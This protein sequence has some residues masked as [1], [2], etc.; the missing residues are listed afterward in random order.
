MLLHIMY[1][2]VRYEWDGEKNRTNQSKHHG[3]TFETAQEVF[4]DPNQVVLENYFLED[5]GEQRYQ[6]IGIDLDFVLPVVFVNRSI[7]GEEII[8]IVSAQERPSNMKKQPTRSNS[9]RRIKVTVQ[10]PLSMFLDKSRRI[11]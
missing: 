7:E 6:A 3:I 4:D 11:V 8:H 1:N 2:R 9:V 10:V 5:G